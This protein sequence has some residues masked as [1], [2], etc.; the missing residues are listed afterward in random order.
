MSRTNDDH[1]EAAMAQYFSQA[2][3]I[4]TAESYCRGY[5]TFAFIRWRNHLG[6]AIPALTAGRSRAVASHAYEQGL[7]E[8]LKMRRA[9]NLPSGEGTR[10][11][12]QHLRKS[13]F[14]PKEG[15]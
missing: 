1:D 7:L 6:T 15:R 8:R 3:Q 2:M 9:A 13:E 5:N 11:N 10:P 4:T 12:S 14:A